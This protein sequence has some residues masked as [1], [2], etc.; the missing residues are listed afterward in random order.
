MTIQ[1]LHY[2]FKLKTDK[3]D[4]LNVDSFNDAEIDWVLNYA[5]DVF[6]KQRYGITNNKQYGFE[7]TQKRIDDLKSLHKKENEIVT[8]QI[9]PSLFQANL[10]QIVNPSSQSV[11]DDYWFATRLR[12]QV[13]K[14]D[15]VKN[16]GVKITQTDDLNEALSYKFYKPNFNW[17][18]VLATFNLSTDNVNSAIYLHTDSFTVEKVFIDYIKRPNKVWIGTYTSLDGGNV[19]IVN[20]PINCDLSDSTHEEITTL[21]ASL[22]LGLISDPNFMQLKQQYYEGE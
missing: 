2:S 9:N 5:I 6:V 19:P 12:A 8:S 11:N 10:S 13:K 20:P 7:T 22:A 21:A 18:R 17:G 14:G 1:E 4:S 3:V 16:I 15:C